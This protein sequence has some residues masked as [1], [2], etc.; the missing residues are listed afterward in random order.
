LN[1]KTPLVIITESVALWY[2][3]PENVPSKLSNI[4]VPSFILVTV[5]VAL[6]FG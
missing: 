1:V 6:D 2:K 3:T 5:K 4:D